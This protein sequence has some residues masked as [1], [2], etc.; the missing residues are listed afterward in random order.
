MWLKQKAVS[1]VLVNGTTGEGTTLKV[2]ERMRTAEEWL[3]ACRKHKM[4]C[5]VQIG[6]TSMSEVFELAAHAERISV[7][8]VLCLPDL[9]FKPAVEEDLV[10]YI[11]HIAQYCPTR[12]MFYYH[13]PAFTGVRCKFGDFGCVQRTAHLALE[14]PSS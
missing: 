5:M 2:D 9:F 10:H 12:P 6:G 11:K 7:D 14:P 1:A 13:I 3:K 4:L 8:A